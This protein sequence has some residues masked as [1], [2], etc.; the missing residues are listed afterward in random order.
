MPALPATTRY[1]HAGTAK[2]YFLPAIAAADKTPSRAEITAGTDLTNEIADMS[3]WLVGSGT[4]TTPDLGSTF[5]SNIPGKTSVDASSL[6]FYAD[7]DGDDI[8]SVLPRGTAGFIVIA[9]AGDA[10]DKPADVFPVRVSSVGK[11]RSVGEESARLTVNFAITDEPAEN[12]SLPAT[13]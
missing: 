3:G 9:D 13:A 11:T 7:L 6:T 8:R 10:L 2:V 12:V 4:I 5:E 1:F